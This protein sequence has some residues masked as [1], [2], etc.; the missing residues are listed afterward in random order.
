M[1]KTTITLPEKFDISAVNGLKSRMEKALEKDVSM[2]EIGAQNVEV[3]DSAAVQLLLSFQKQVHSEGR[4]VRFIKASE[5]MVSGTELL[6][7]TQL[8]SLE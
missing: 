6:G 7:A 5:K 8:L 3:L 1:S 2:I 4:E